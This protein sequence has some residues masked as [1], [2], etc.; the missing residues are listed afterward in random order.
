MTKITR[1][2]LTQLRRGEKPLNIS[3]LNF[4]FFKKL[5]SDKCKFCNSEFIKHRENQLY[6]CDKCKVYNYRKMGWYK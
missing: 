4:K 6:C 2:E 5:G 3:K 1:S